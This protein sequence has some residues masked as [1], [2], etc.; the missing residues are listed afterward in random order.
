MPLGKLRPFFDI[1]GDNFLDKYKEN[2]TGFFIGNRRERLERIGEKDDLPIIRDDGGVVFLHQQKKLGSLF[3]CH[4][5]IIAEGI[6]S[7][8]GGEDY[9][10][11][12][13]IYNGSR[14]K[15]ILAY[16][17]GLAAE[18]L[19][20]KLEILGAVLGRA[21]SYQDNL[22]ILTYFTDEPVDE[23]EIKSIQEVTDTSKFIRKSFCDW[24]AF[25]NIVPVLFVVLKA[26]FFD[27]F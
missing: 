20:F 6:I 19:Q 10:D 25:A 18:E 14:S 13:G 22:F 5:L 21:V 8:G 9:H 4:S 1:A 12:V 3:F 27:E 7:A 16:D 11:R 23:R 17:D 26:K 24:L 2:D 15:F